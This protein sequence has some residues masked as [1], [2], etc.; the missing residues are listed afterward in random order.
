MR[1]GKVLII[2]WPRGRLQNTGQRHGKGAIASL[3]TSL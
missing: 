2:W 3:T 1:S